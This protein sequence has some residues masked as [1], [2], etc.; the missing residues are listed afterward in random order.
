[1]FDI[2]ENLKKLP[3]VPGV[4][5]HKDKLGHVIYVGKAISLR[6]RVRQYFQSSKNMDAKVHAMVGHIAEFEY[7]TCGSEM[8]AFILEC[9]LIKKYQ[10]KYNIL[11]RD[12]KTYPYI[13]VTTATER[14]PRVIKTRRIKQD[15]DKYFGPYS[16]VG[17]VNQMIE[18]LNDVY[19][20]KWC[21]R[22]VF[23]K[24]W[25]P[26]LHYHIGQ[27]QGVCIGKIREDAYREAI[28]SVLEFLKGRNK[29]INV[30]LKEKMEAASEAMEYEKAALYRDYLTAAKA[31]SEKQRVVMKT[32]KD[33]D[34]ILSAGPEHVVV[35]FVREGKLVGRESY[36]IHSG[37]SEDSR[38][39]ISGFLKLH[40]GS[41]ASGPSELLLGR[42]VPEQA[43]VADY[44]TSLWGRKVDITVPKKGE[45]K[46]LLDLA[47]R[48]VTEM[49]A[50]MEDRERNKKEREE[51]L[52][53][54]IH[55][56]LEI[57]GN[58]EPYDGK[59]YRVEA[60]DISNTNGVDTVGG[61]VVFQ[62]MQP[63][64]KS[65]RRFRIRTV[66]GPDD[67]ASMQEMLYRRFRRGKKGDPAFRKM[68]DAL[69]IDGGRGHVAAAKQVTDA[70]HINI[71]VLGMAKDNSHRTRALVWEK[72]GVF[73]EEELKGHPLVFTFLGNVQE[74]VHRF[75][76]SY[77][78]SIRDS[79]S[80]HSVLDEIEG[81]GPVKRNRLLAA[82][83]SVAEIKE[84]DEE[85][86]LAV[87]GITK[88]NARAIMNFF[89]K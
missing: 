1:M 86:L 9:N 36:G 35:F 45:K 19:H 11:L 22:Q 21:S 48:D 49:L 53:K 89:Q 71:P 47:L 76:I 78:R 28:A 29:K 63:D 8:E 23:S 82:L 4:Y 56:I 24:G 69:L 75:A 77:H 57:W 50:T 41:Q 6:N 3:A 42:D 79:K 12:D 13:K 43:M 60:Y 52:G 44:L 55:D 68:P 54:Q 51:N 46:A 16:D 2:E 10:P 85:T 64:K 61:L 7:I 5:M 62:G 67:Y 72:D 58:K 87:E 30:Y 38:E 40:Y 70:L 39:K 27:C 15:G 84:A 37:A 66:D 32:S 33:M 25:R 74:E 17:A 14:F 34:V 26:C 18:L 65:Y 83:G 73:F 88:G 81:I 20:L 59:Q 80:L 31:I